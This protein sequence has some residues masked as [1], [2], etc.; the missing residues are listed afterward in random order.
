MVNYLEGSINPNEKL[1]I[2]IEAMAV[3]WNVDKSDAGLDEIYEHY[4]D[5]KAY[6]DEEG[7][8]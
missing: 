3:Q 7:I 5:Q 6:N 4:L 8:W 1:D 2:P